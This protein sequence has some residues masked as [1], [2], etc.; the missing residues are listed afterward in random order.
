[1]FVVDYE[2]LHDIIMSMAFIIMAVL[3]FSRVTVYNDM[4]KYMPSFSKKKQETSR[5]WS[6]ELGTRWTISFNHNSLLLWFTCF[7]RLAYYISPSW[8]SNF[9]TAQCVVLVLVLQ[10]R[11]VNHVW[12]H[13]QVP[14]TFHIAATFYQ[15]CSVLWI[16]KNIN[17][18]MAENPYLFVKISPLHIPSVI[19]GITLSF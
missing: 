16:H 11:L 18:T 15:A 2:M 3:K 14:V 1:M 12:W 5:L 4:L 10:V 9:W 6:E 17:R 19:V 7:V 8:L 13:R